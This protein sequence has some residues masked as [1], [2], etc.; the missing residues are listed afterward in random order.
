MNRKISYKYA[1]G[2]AMA[3]FLAVP[4]SAFATPMN[5]SFTGTFSSDDDVQLFNFTADGASTVRLISFGYGGGMQSDGNNVVAGGFDPILALFDGVGNLV[6]QNDDSGS[7]TTGACGIDVVTPDPITNQQWDTCFD[8][9]LAQGS[10]TVAIM[11]YDNFA[12]GPTLAAG[13]TYAGDPFFTNVIN[14]CS[15]GQFCDASGDPA[16][17][18]RTNAWAFDIMNVETAEAVPEPSIIALFGL[19][20]LGLGLAGRRKA[21]STT[22]R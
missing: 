17:S 6:G 22:N 13:F 4:G 7:S 5:Y 19:G 1:Q 10:Y 2:I 20:L 3:L 12:I 18:N 21:K 14:G 11:Q 15:N 8:Q 9:T 16:G